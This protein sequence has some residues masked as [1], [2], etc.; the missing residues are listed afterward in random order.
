MAHDLYKITSQCDTFTT[1]ERDAFT[2]LQDEVRTA[3]TLPVK[4]N[5]FEDNIEAWMHKDD[6]L[7]EDLWIYQVVERHF[8]RLNVTEGMALLDTSPDKPFELYEAIH[9][10]IVHI[11]NTGTMPLALGE[12]LNPYLEDLFLA[13][14]RFHEHKFDSA[15]MRASIMDHFDIAEESADEMIDDLHAMG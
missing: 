12:T 3:A 5:F 2:L 7:W 15:Q 8:K 11:F 1:E 4:T 9:K 10:C 14:E 6:V 13:K